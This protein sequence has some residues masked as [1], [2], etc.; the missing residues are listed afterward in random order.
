MPGS[1]AQITQHHEVFSLFIGHIFICPVMND[2]TERAFPCLFPWLPY[3]SP[4]S[5]YLTFTF[6]IF[7]YCV[8]FLAPPCGLLIVLHSGAVFR[9]QYLFRYSCQILLLSVLQHNFPIVDVEFRLVPAYVIAPHPPSARKIIVVRSYYYSGIRSYEQY[10]HSRI[11]YF[12]AWISSRFLYIN[13]CTGYHIPSY[14][15]LIETMPLK[16]LKFPISQLSL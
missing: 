1:M 15:F 6:F 10:Y 16:G 13:T 12:K 11:R 3:P 5:T 7:Q 8:P 4:S 9:G 14:T 2:K